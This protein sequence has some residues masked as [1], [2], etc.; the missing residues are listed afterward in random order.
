MWATA[1]TVLI[2]GVPV[3]LPA[4]EVNAKDIQVPLRKSATLLEPPMPHDEGSWLGALT[5]LRCSRIRILPN[6]SGFPVGARRVRIETIEWRGKRH[7]PSVVVLST[8]LQEQRALDSVG[9]ASLARL[10][11]GRYVLK[12]RISKQEAIGTIDVP[13]D[14]ASCTDDLPIS[15]ADGYWAIGGPQKN[16]E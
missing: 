1:L 13:K 14:A 6:N 4:Q 9:S 2:G 3:L 5:Q 11:P 7:E 16:R 8:R 10:K 12:V 15:Q